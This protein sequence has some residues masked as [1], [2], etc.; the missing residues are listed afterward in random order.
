MATSGKTQI[1]KSCF[2][3]G[4][5]LG[6]NLK[7]NYPVPEVASMFK[8]SRSCPLNVFFCVFACCAFFCSL[9][10]FYGKNKVFLNKRPPSRA[11]NRVRAFVEDTSGRGYFWILRLK[12]SPVLVIVSILKFRSSVN[13]RNA[14]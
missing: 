6:L 8:K 4:R 2:N 5:G 10:N 3:L 9:L 13:K 1:E 14:I 11:S 7:N 12:E